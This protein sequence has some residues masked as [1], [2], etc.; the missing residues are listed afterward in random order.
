LSTKLG[1]AAAGTSWT[2]CEVDGRDRSAFSVQRENTADHDASAV[3]EM[4]DLIGESVPLIRAHKTE[5]ALEMKLGHNWIVKV[6]SDNDCE[7]WQMYSSNGERL[8]AIPGGGIA[9]WRA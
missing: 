7:A 3:P 8:I 2:N 5:G 1:D 4:S 6:E 9:V